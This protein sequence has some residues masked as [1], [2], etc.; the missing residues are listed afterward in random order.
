[1][2]RQLF[3][4]LYDANDTFWWRFM[5][6]FVQNSPESEWFPFVEAA[7]GNE[8]ACKLSNLIHNWNTEENG[9][10]IFPHM[11][12]SDILFF[13]DCE[14]YMSQTCS[15]FI[16]P[17]NKNE[18]LQ[19]DLLQNSEEHI[20]ISSSKQVKKRTYNNIAC[21]KCGKSYHHPDAVRK[22]ARSKHPEWIETCKGPKHYIIDTPVSE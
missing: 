4:A 17:E 1:M 20:N 15:T 19:K 6:T 13:M 8:C 16:F 11:K 22:H 12:V 3:R 10:P 2:N 18:S 9:Q 14:M 21:K 7:F 5:I